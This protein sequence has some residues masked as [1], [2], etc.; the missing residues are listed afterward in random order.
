MVTN[1]AS[2]RPVT[3][4]CERCGRGHDLLIP[5]PGSGNLD[6]ARIGAR[7]RWCA[8]CGRTVGRACCWERGA[9]LCPDCAALRF[10]EDPSLTDVV[11]TR[12]ALSGL[13]AATDAMKALVGQLPGQGVADEGRAR[14]AW[15]DAWLEAGIGIVRAEGATRTARR[16]GMAASVTRDDRRWLNDQ[17]ESHG[18]SWDGRQRAVADALERV[19]LRLRALAARA[20]AADAPT[21]PSPEPALVPVPMS[22]AE[23][24]AARLDA[25]E[26]APVDVRPPARPGPRDR[27]PQ[28]EMEPAPHPGPAAVAPWPPSKAA[29]RA[30]LDILGPPVA[31]GGRRSLGARLEPAPRLPRSARAAVAPD[32]EGR[33]VLARSTSARPAPA[34][35]PLAPTRPPATP[36]WA[37]EAP[38]RPSAG[39]ER[40]VGPQ[41]VIVI[42]V[43]LAFIGLV[44]TAAVVV[45]LFGVAAA[46][47][48]AAVSGPSLS[49]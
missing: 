43:L 41:A 49:A 46:S 14:G 34:W 28:T 8:G 3:G 19:G 21:V 18:A 30:E 38:T 1:A 32:W 44:V 36:R 33:P 2:E 29:A 26:A 13:L 9:G 10:A 35:P 40:A 22:D 4:S 31:G 39:R 20:R 16:R 47:A 25:R 23:P 11:L 24:A 48:P 27:E 42:L 5:E 12:T 7:F 37:P 15:E 6:F 17:L 45:Q